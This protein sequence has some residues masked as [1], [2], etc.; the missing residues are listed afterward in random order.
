MLK[1]IALKIFNGCAQNIRKCLKLD[2]YYYLC[3]D[4][5]FTHSGE[6]LYN[7]NQQNVVDDTFFATNGQ[8]NS[9]QQANK[10]AINIS[11]IVGKN[12]DGKSSLVEIII[13][14]INN[15]AENA[16]V[17]NAPLQHIY[18]LRA[19]LVYQYKDKIYKII[20][21]GYKNGT[22]LIE[23]ATISNGIIRTE[24]NKMV[25]GT[26]DIPF[27]PLFYTWISNYSH[28]AYNVYDFKKEWSVDPLSV[29]SDKEA[30]DACWLYPIF[31]K[32]DGYAVPLALHPYRDCG[33]IDVNK[34]TDLSKQR[35]IAMFINSDDAPSS[36]RHI[37]GN[38]AVGIKLKPIDYSKLQKRTLENYLM[39]VRTENFSLDW[40][41]KRIQSLSQNVSEIRESVLENWYD[42]E[43]QE[44]NFI[45]DDLM[46]LRQNNAFV[47]AEISYAEYLRQMD[48]YIKEYIPNCFAYKKYNNI[49][50]QPSDI[51]KYLLSLG[52]L[53]KRLSKSKEYSGLSVYLEVRKQNKRYKEYRN[54][55][56]PQLARLY[57]IYQ[58]AMYYGINPLIVCKPFD[59]LSEIEKS[60]HYLIYKTI[61]IFET[62]PAYSELLDKQKLPWDRCYEYS[63][64]ELE[65]LFNLIEL[66]KGVKS[67]RVR[68]L[69]QTLHYIEESKSKGEIYTYLARYDDEE[70]LP[71]QNDDEI[72]LRLNTL[73]NY[74][75]SGKIELEELPPPIYECE[76]LFERERQLVV[77]SGLSSGEKQMLNVIGAVIYHL[78]N[79]DSGK[80]YKTVNIILEEIELYFH[81]EYQRQIVNRLIRQIKGEKLPNM[82]AVNILFVTH[83][84]FIL[85]D[86]PKGNVL[87]LREGNP[88][89]SMQ[90][91]T[92]GANIHS[93]LKNGFFLPNLPMGEFAYDKIN[94]LFGKLNASAV[95]M[96]EVAVIEQEIAIVGEPYLR[97]QL[98]K[99]FYSLPQVKYYYDSKA[100][101]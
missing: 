51:A 98:Y 55:N 34:E 46:G 76:I 43:R 59:D 75:E 5:Y 22:Q 50:K 92:F 84:P 86:I 63:P 1:L 72:V 45:L 24:N 38:V 29:S 30:N 49:P 81:P 27:P 70:S 13:R 15:L 54:Y 17:Y 91:N 31:N 69:L 61:S 25:Q 97:E 94:A 6:L 20:E 62:Y 21:D 12:G 64:Q 87:F 58:V 14:L 4:F 73:K 7:N 93:L 9:E 83:S 100:R 88:D 60:Q 71:N 37:T 33:N 23:Y 82:D 56:I 74:V 66:D 78:H 85:S 44:V 39:S 32:N 47:N 96:D 35:L 80:I 90:E 95:T 28:Y 26:K 41:F 18:G 11:A 48:K 40:A 52:T 57:L 36:F 67:H 3:N 42:E 65:R 2:I 68:K 10:I 77:Q 79:I 8:Q 99:L 53:Q 89:T 101:K 16:K 19:E